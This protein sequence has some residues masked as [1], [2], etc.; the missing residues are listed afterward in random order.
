MPKKGNFTTNV[1][2]EFV[3]RYRK[4]LEPC[5]MVRCFLANQDSR[6]VWRKECLY[7][8]SP[9]C[10][11]SGG[12]GSVMFVGLFFP[13][14]KR[15]FS[16]APVLPD[17]MKQFVLEENAS[18]GRGS[19]FPAPFFLAV[20]PPLREITALVKENYLLLNWH[21]RNGAIGL[22]GPPPNSLFGLTAVI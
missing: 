9:V 4:R 20:W 14:F 18:E 13:Q 7:R 19:A 12:G 2:L 22:R 10:K 5:S 3:K 6:S 11:H 21:L 15:R 1:S 16:S 17:S 8:K